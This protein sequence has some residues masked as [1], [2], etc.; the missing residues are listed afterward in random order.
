MCTFYHRIYKCSPNPHEPQQPHKHNSRFVILC[1]QSIKDRIRPETCPAFQ[2]TTIL[3]AWCCSTDCCQVSVDSAQ[4][5]YDAS[6]HDDPNTAQDALKERNS[7]IKHH[8]CH[9][10]QNLGSK[11]GVSNIE[12][13]HFSPKPWAKP[14]KPL[15]IPSYG[16]FSPIS[17]AEI[18]M[19][20]HGFEG[21]PRTVTERAVYERFRREEGGKGGVPD[22]SDLG[23]EVN[24]V[25]TVGV[26]EMSRRN[27]PQMMEEVKEV[28]QDPRT[29]VYSLRA[30]Q[31]GPVNQRTQGAPALGPRSQHPLGHASSSQQPPGRGVEDATEQGTESLERNR[32]DWRQW[33]APG[34]SDEHSSDEEMAEARPQGPPTTRPQQWPSNVFR[35]TRSDA[36]DAMQGIEQ[37]NRG[38]RFWG[39]R[40][41]GV[42]LSLD[43]MVIRN[44]EIA[45][46]RVGRDRMDRGR[47]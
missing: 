28:D 1:P 41:E 39:P 34:S 46:S 45:R 10:L 7:L 2:N 31:P 44:D 26:E 14:V 9:C 16:G 21:M 47:S 40:D 13:L 15:I 18:S 6:V 36:T 24:E 38:E 23:E 8:A 37:R 30:L 42:S 3:A 19:T 25:V 11:G 33:S 4:A 27:R 5:E 29:Q 35:D 22:L 17:K 12:R 43:D 20:L 32:R